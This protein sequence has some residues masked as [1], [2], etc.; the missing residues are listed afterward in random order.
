MTHAVQFPVP[1]RALSALL[2]AMALVVGC[3]GGD[4]GVGT[5]GTGSP[6]SFSQGPI[7]GFGSIIV[8]GVHFDD[9]AASVVDDDGS[10]LSRSQDLRLG[11]VVDVEG[12]AVSNNAATATTIRVHVDL[13]G[14]VT[15]AWNAASGRL[16]VLGQP[17]RVVSTTALDGIAG[18]AAAIAAGSTVK[19]SSLYDLA[20]G[21]YVATRIDPAPGAAHFAIRG[22]PSAI[23]ASAHTFTIG[24]GV[25]SYGNV[26]PPTPFAA[27]QALRAVLATAPDGQGRW[28]VTAF[29]PARAALPDGRQGGVDGVVSSVA[30]AMHFVVDGFAV[31]ATNAKVTPTG[32]TVGVQSRVVVQGTVTGGVLVATSVHV[33]AAHDDEDDQGGAGAHGG[34]GNANGADAVQ[35]DGPILTLDT[36][37]QTF[38]MRGPTTVSY[39]TASFDNGKATDLA[40]GVVVKMSGNL[41]ADGTYVVADKLTLH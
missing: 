36:A 24:G 6:Q 12:G 9:G 19:V 40:V 26:A 30:D 4:S 1:W 23:D 29:G 37:R 34:N 14:P 22:A 2:A 35:I 7:S 15:T 41:S 27:G 21:V 10:A 8:N 39:A 33:R 38:T 25:F 11:T 16:A 20:T 5:G 3:G 28:V 17:V 32:A 18:G 31:D 13:L